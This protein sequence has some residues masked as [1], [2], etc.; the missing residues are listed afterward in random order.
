[1]YTEE[2]QIEIF[3]RGFP[4]MDIVAPA[5]P[6]NG[7][8]HVLDDKAIEEC[9]SYAAAAKVSGRCKLV[10]ASGAAS[11]MFKDIF[12]GLEQTNEAVT[13]LRDNIKRFAFYSEALF[14]G[15]D[16]AEVVLRDSG[17]GYASKPKGVILFH[18]YPDGECRSAIAEH[19]VEGQAYMRNDDDSVN[20]EFTVSPDHKELF[21]QAFADVREC[22]EQRYGVRYSLRLSC[23]DPATDTIAV[24][25]EGKPFLKEDGT[26][27][28]RPAGHGALI[29]NLNAMPEELVY[30]KNIDN[31]A[32]ERYLPEISAYK[33]A[34]AGCALRLRD[35]IFA[36]LQ[37]L[38]S[39]PTPELCA[40]IED[41]LAKEL[42]VTIPQNADKVSALR[43]KLDRPIRVCGMVRRQG[44][45]GGGPYI[46]RAADGSTSLQILEGVQ[47]DASDP[48]C[49]EALDAST[50]FNPVDL[51][52]CLH[53][54]RGGKFDLLRHVDPEAGFISSKSY[55]G[56]EL[57]A[58]E[59]PGLW[60]GAMSD[61]NTM[62]VEVPLSTFNPVKVVNDLLREAHQ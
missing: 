47:I 44:E 56:R 20:I 30:I 14:A 53:D 48:H 21:E 27:L 42:S 61:W 10:P 52:C 23:Q 1:M 57:R 16:P 58:L 54:S 43:S 17:L 37:A 60:N 55:Q 50:H 33:Q 24:D 11:R 8:I 29:Y 22:Y 59:L 19:L 45:P 25:M 9:R 7:G 4:R 13:V 62:F 12:S 38:D 6:G 39:D 49:A 3:R 36:Y 40:E 31:V 15:K 35:R 28:R 2:Q 5:T 34:L 18:R 51:V 32:Q 46:V 26:V 41:F